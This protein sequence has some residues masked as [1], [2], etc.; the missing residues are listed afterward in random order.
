MARRS[1]REEYLSKIHA[2]LEKIK[3]LNLLIILMFDIEN[4]VRK[5]EAIGT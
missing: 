2:D 1:E 3:D 5:G 4:E